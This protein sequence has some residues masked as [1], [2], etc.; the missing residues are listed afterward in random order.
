MLRRWI[1]ICKLS[2]LTWITVLASP[3]G[4]SH[5]LD[6]TR[7]AI[8]WDSDEY[9][10][11][12]PGPHLE[13]IFFVN[14]GSYLIRECVEPRTRLRLPGGTTS[15]RFV[16]IHQKSDGH[17]FLKSEYI[18]VNC[19]NAMQITQNGYQVSNRSGS[20]NYQLDEFPDWYHISGA[21]HKLT[22]NIGSLDPNGYWGHPVKYVNKKVLYL[23]PS[24]EN[25]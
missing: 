25:Q 23:C 14:H 2:I 22:H 12:C 19:N 1:P 18:A 9:P 7:D 16:R 4:A 24:F 3:A 13:S 5:I 8:Y 20:Y 15:A 21:K 17:I 6:M 10:A 11:Q